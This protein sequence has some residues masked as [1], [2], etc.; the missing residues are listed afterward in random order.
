MIELADRP[1]LRGESIFENCAFARLLSA[2]C[3]LW[4]PFFFFPEPS[5]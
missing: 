5:G 4:P 1:K 2:L 3:D